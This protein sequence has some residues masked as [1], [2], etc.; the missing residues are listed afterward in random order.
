MRGR[1]RQVS[2]DL[3]TGAVFQGSCHHLR[4]AD[5]GPQHAPALQRLDHV[6]GSRPRSDNRGRPAPGGAVVVVGIVK[7]G[8]FAILVSELGEPR[9]GGM[10]VPKFKKGDWVTSVRRGSK[11]SFVGEI[12]DICGDE[13]VIRDA[14]KLRWLRKPAELSL[15]IIQEGGRMI[16]TGT[17]NHVGQWVECR[18]QVPR[19]WNAAKR[20]PEPRIR[21]DRM[22]TLNKLDAFDADRLHR[23]LNRIVAGLRRAAGAAPLSDHVSG[24]SAPAPN[25]AGVGMSAS[26]R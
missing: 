13:Y 12:I 25:A 23:K 11:G 4:H 14:E 5:S 24:V 19:F 8:L 6:A 7:V 2:R 10:P 20:T 17:S 22:I 1:L 21:R 15:R 18:G 26:L 3:R 16:R 9:R